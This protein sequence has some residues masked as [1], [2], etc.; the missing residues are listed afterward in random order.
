M[1]QQ[2]VRCAV[3]ANGYTTTHE[4]RSAMRRD[5][6]WRSP[7]TCPPEDSSAQK[8]TSVYCRSTWQSADRRPLEQVPTVDGVGRLSAE[9]Q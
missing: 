1:V 6:E 7:H 9:T 8:P 3:K 4:I 5:S 2:V